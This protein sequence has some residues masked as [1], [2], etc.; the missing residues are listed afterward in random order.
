MARRPTPDRLR[1]R[2]ARVQRLQRYQLRCGHSR[3]RTVDLK[4]RKIRVNAVSPGVI[5]TP[6]HSSLMSDEQIEQYKA[7]TSG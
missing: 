7:S 1:Q 2:H 3:G 4:E 5:I 6:A